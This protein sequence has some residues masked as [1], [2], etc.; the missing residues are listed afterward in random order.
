MFA[1][2]KQAL[3]AIVFAAVISFAAVNTNGQCYRPPLMF[4]N[5]VLQSGTAGQVNAV[6]RFPQVTIGVDAFVTILQRFGGASLSAIDNTTQGYSDAWQPLVSGPTSNGSIS[7]IRWRIE[8]RNATTGVPV[9]YACFSISAIDVDGDNA[10]IREFVEAKGANSYNTASN[11]V[12]TI[13][14]AGDSIR[15]TGQVTTRPGIDTSAWDTNIDFNFTN[16]SSIEIKTGA[17]VVSNS[18]DPSPERYNC[19]FFKQIGTPLDGPGAGPLPVRYG[20]FSGNVSNQK[21]KLHWTTEVEINHSHFEVER[22]FD[23]RQFQTAGIV[24]DALTRQGGTA[25][26]AFRDQHAA[27]NQHQVVYYRLKQVDNDGKINYSQVLALRLRQDQAAGLVVAPN[28]FQSRFTLQVKSE[29]AGQAHIQIQTLNGQT[30]VS[31]QAIVYA[32]QNTLQVDG[33]SSLSAGVYMA[34]IWVNDVPVGVQKV[35][36]Q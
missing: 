1:I 17:R 24:L 13:T 4:K 5:A 22:S 7:Y 16:V 12:L 6:Y 33:L 32:G 2:S 9:N 29:Q 14:S 34:R 15:A 35:V 30:L 26:Y 8:F 21:V 3:R 10:R 20:S 25:N 18:G 36:K 31:K 19:L 28:P 11:T 23:N 27:F